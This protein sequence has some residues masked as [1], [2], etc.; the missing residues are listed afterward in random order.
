MTVHDRICFLSQAAEFVAVHGGKDEAK[1]S[2][3]L[4]YIGRE[5]GLKY[6]VSTPGWEAIKRKRCKVCFMSL[7]H[8]NTASFKIKKAKFTITCNQCF[9][10]KGKRYPVS[11]SPK[12]HYEKQ[13]YGT[14]ENDSFTEK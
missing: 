1:L 4:N 14:K 5:I 6:Q 3:F 7:S 8:P 12:T 10:S 11:D 13:M 9:T 2:C